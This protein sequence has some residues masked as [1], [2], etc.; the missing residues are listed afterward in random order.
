MIAVIA[1]ETTLLVGLLGSYFGLRDRTAYLEAEINTYKKLLSFD[2]EYI[3]LLRM[4]N[5]SSTG[6]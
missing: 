2:D 6:D 4:I 1:I 5:E 3:K